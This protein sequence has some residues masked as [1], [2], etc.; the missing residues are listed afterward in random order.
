GRGVRGEA[1]RLAFRG[2][3]RRSFLLER[4][5]LVPVGRYKVSRPVP[6]EPLPGYRSAHAVRRI[7]RLQVPQFIDAGPGTPSLRIDTKRIERPGR[8]CH[9]FPVGYAQ[10]QVDDGVEPRPGLHV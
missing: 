7:P 4:R 6:V 10:V 5:E 1:I 9:R 3:A 2:T 8:A